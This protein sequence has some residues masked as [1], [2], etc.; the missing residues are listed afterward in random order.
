[1]PGE[2]RLVR[3]GSSR[4]SGSIPGGN[5]NEGSGRQLAHGKFRFRS[6]PAA[7]CRVPFRRPSG[8]AAWMTAQRR[9]VARDALEQAAGEQ[10]RLRLLAVLAGDEETRNRRAARGELHAERQ[11]AA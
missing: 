11:A 9:L 3:F 10:A 5:V 2:E 1:M 7:F 4:S 8:F 6:T